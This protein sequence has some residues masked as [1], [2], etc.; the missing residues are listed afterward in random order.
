M[1][2]NITVDG[3]A[4]TLPGVLTIRELI[5]QC[6]KKDPHLIVER[7][8]AFVYPQDYA[9]VRVEDGDRIELIIPD[10]GG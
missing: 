1:A 4:R 8:G 7:N 3:T 6:N 5:E 2:L 9:H 10:F